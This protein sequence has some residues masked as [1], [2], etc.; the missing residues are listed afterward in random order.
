VLT[1]KIDDTRQESASTALDIGSRVSAREITDRY[2]DIAARGLTLSA[3]QRN[4]LRTPFREVKVQIPVRMD[5][6]SLR[7]F[8]GGSHTT[9]RCARA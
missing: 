6:G 4:L 5:D 9:Q 1:V 8:Q 7:V 3:E 2:F